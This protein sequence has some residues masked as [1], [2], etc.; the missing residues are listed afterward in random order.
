MSAARKSPRSSSSLHDVLPKLALTPSPALQP[1][2]SRRH[3]SGVSAYH[4]GRD[5][6]II[7]FRDQ[8]TYLYTH[9]KPGRA[10]VE[11]MQRLAAEGRGLAT[12]ISRHVRAHYARRLR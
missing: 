1:Y 11:A 2:A 6:I 3:N 5:F 8:R 7:E 12:Y 10:A 4:S 9:E